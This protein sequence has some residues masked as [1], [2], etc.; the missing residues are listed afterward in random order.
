MWSHLTWS[1]SFNSMLKPSILLSLTHTQVL[2][3]PLVSCCASFTYFLY[4][5]S[6]WDWQIFYWRS[7]VAFSLPSIKQSINQSIKQSSN[8]SIIF[9]VVWKRFV[10][11]LHSWMIKCMMFEGQNWGKVPVLVETE[12]C[13][14]KEA[15]VFFHKEVFQ[16]SREIA[17][18]I[19]RKLLLQ[20]SKQKKGGCRNPD[21]RHEIQA[22]VVLKKEKKKL[23]LSCLREHLLKVSFWYRS[24]GTSCKEIYLSHPEAVFFSL[25]HGCECRGR[26]RRGSKCSRQECGWWDHNNKSTAAAAARGDGGSGFSRRGEF[27]AA[28]QFQR[29]SIQTVE[30][31]EVPVGEVWGTS[32]A[33]PWQRVHL[34][35]LSSELASWTHSPLHLL[36]PQR[37]P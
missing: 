32:R 2:K 13:L 23:V 21:Y 6:C 27:Q 37:N 29:Q 12:A 11:N 5:V 33:S 35:T 25:Y 16:A 24:T 28:R 30:Q 8:L 36:F 4:F 15:R 7:E 20:E 31:G 1:P 3:S 10:Q 14:T 9:F 19:T 18:K 17:I 22:Q 34:R 26:R